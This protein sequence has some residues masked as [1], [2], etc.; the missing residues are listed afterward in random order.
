MGVKI[1]PRFNRNGKKLDKGEKARISIGVYWDSKKRKFIHTDYYVTEQQWDSKKLVVNHHHENFKFINAKISDIISKL[2]TYQYRL[3]SNG[4]YLTPD[5]LDDFVRR[6]FENSTSMTF[7]EFLAKQLRSRAFNTKSTYSAHQKTLNKFNAFKKEVHF[8][9]LTVALVEQFDEFMKQQGLMTNSRSNH[10]KTLKANLHIAATEGYIEHHKIPYSTQLGGMAGKFKVR[11]ENGSI[12][13]LDFE[14]RERIEK[15][16]YSDT[17]HLDRYRKIFLFM[18]YTGLRISDVE[19]LRPEHLHHTSKGYQVDLKKMIKTRKPVY[20]E[21]HELFEG[22]PQAI[23]EEFFEETFGSSDFSAIRASKENKPVFSHLTGQVLN[24]ELKKIAE[25]A[26][27]YKNLS[28]HVGRHTFGTHMAVL[29][30]GNVSLV[31]DL[32]GHGKTETTMVYIRLAEKMRGQML[33]GV[34]WSAH[35][36]ADEA[37]EPSIINSTYESIKEVIP[38]KEQ[39]SSVDKKTTASPAPLEQF[40]S[41]IYEKVLPELDLPTKG[42]AHFSIDEES[43]QEYI[44]RLPFSAKDYEMFQKSPLEIK[45]FIQEAEHIGK[46]VDIQEMFNN[47]PWVKGACLKLSV[48]FMP[49]LNEGNIVL[50]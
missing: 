1:R 44:S 35:Q 6:N 4:Q 28:A 21:L 47:H 12:V 2:E 25:D 36:P 43:L 22:K 14:E 17:P 30:N 15:L 10:H 5:L 50:I 29:S 20:L 8:H 33:K 23:L 24:R 39:P 34:N 18:C 9:E 3:E 38:Q 7:N 19:N 11:K 26:E 49:F 16:D 13:N 45:G 40:K 37:R 32:L 46:F 48:M 42:Q 27:I 41:T 31:R